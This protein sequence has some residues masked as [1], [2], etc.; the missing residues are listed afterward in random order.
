[1][2]I[3]EQLRTFE[4]ECACGRRHESALKKVLIEKGAIEKLPEILREF[5]L[6]KPFLLSDRN[7]YEAA[8]KRVEELLKAQGFA[9]SGYVFPDTALKPD[10]K[11]VG[12]AVV[13]FDKRCDVVISIGSGV[14]NDIGKILSGTAHTFYI[15]IGTA[16]SMDGY[17]SAS[18][19]MD[20][21]GLKV[22]LA[23]RSADVII[24]DIDVLNRAPAHMKKSGLGDMLA[25]YV[26]ICEWRIAHELLGEYY[27]ERIAGFVR[28]ALKKCVDNA[29]GLL[30]GDENAVKAVFEGLVITGV[31][32]E[33]AGLSRPASGVEHYFSHVWDM[34]GLEFGTPVDLHG[35]QCAIG[36]RLA[37]EKYEKIK[38]L[39]PNR[40]KAC[41]YVRAFDFE[42]WSKTLREFLG[43]AAEP[44]IAAEQ[45]DGKYSV[46]KHEKRFAIIER[47]WDKI[48]QIIGEELPSLEEYDRILDTIAAPKRL[49]EIGID[50]EILPLSFRAT[51]DIRDKYVLSRLAW[52]LGVIEEL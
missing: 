14:L 12:K 28:G 20:V 23:T 7:T 51:K 8:G 24:G 22:S 33:Y 1:M 29:K 25:K 26:S 18:S 6:T 35:I 37:I 32:M 48:L 2:D 41:A 11:A 21:D 36:S 4:G 5:S 39:V 43:R 52:D 40:E 30:G 44:M 46:E 34:R 15:I 42:D 17:A 31:A 10:E 9:C 16:P 50:E 49:Q 3:L 19:S 45:K 27:C 38:T 47:K 13:H